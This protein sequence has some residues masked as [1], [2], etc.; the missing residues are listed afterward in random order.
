MNSSKETWRQ[1]WLSSINELTSLDIQTRMWLAPENQNPHWTF[2]EFMCCYFDDLLVDKGY[3]VEL[4]SGLISYEEFEIIKEWHETI[5]KYESPN[6]NDYD[7]SA[8]LNDPKWQD[9]LRLG[10]I[11]KAR[12][13]KIIDGKESQFL[14]D[15]KDN[16]SIGNS[17]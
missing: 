6:K 15:T 13:S 4:A 7:N 16:Q 14:S 17:L 5:A 3:D 10:K 11:A 9:I 8:I 1:N 12:L 2:I